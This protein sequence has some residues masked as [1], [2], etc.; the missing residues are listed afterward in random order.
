VGGMPTMLFGAVFCSGDRG[1]AAERLNLVQS[2]R[3]YEAREF[4]L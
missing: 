4:F 1:A 2:D 3:L